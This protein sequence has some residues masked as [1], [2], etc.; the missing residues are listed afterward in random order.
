MAL[1]QQPSKWTLR[2]PTIRVGVLALLAAILLVLPLALAPRADAYVYWNNESGIGRA[3]LDGTAIDES[4]IVLGHPGAGSVAVDARHI[5]WI[6]RDGI[7]R[8][9]L[10]GT[11]VDR[12]FIPESS[13][14]IFD[15]GAALA[16]DKQHIYW[17]WSFPAPFPGGT[18]QTAIARA[19][20]DGTG[21]ERNF[22]LLG[23]GASA[24]AVD[25]NYIYW[26]GGNVIGR[27]GIDGRRIEQDFIPVPVPPNSPL[28]TLGAVEV[29]AEHVYWLNLVAG[30]SPGPLVSTIARA[31]L[32]GTAID[33]RF[34]E[35]DA[36]PTDLAV[37]AEHLYWLNQPGYPSEWAASISRANLNGSA[38][39]QGFIARARNDQASSIA[40]D[41]LTADR[42]AGEASAAK[43]QRQRG[44]RIIV[45]VRIKAKERL[46]AKATGKIKVNPTYKLKS[47]KVKLARGETKTLKLKPKKA[48]AKKI[49][50]GLKRGEKAKARL[51]VKL[52][53][54][55]GN[56]EAER[57]TVRLKR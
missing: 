35:L 50:A 29:D 32:D 43:T 25:D 22:V 47:K 9:K 36:L 31:N 48:E 53:G 17:T 34:L 52:T 51:S 44:K 42:V 20:L 4:F 7:G 16:V 13:D 14:V 46:T 54:L 12:R 23:R 3:N 26:T 30:T 40:I 33:V 11:G 24:I 21:V 8:A 37:D 28:A 56:R 5:Y 15:R 41:A 55:A 2:S 27:A 39:D 45:K 1:T 49:A 10:D 6:Q 57:F 19:N 38:V 18:Y